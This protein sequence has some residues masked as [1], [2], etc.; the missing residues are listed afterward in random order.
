MSDLDLPA[1]PPDV[2]STGA[3]RGWTPWR[4]SRSADAPARRDAAATDPALTA[5][6]R[7]HRLT[8]FFTGRWAGRRGEGGLAEGAVAD[9]VEDS[10]RNGH[11]PEW[12]IVEAEPTSQV[13]RDLVH[14]PGVAAWALGDRL[15]GHGGGTGHLTPS[16]A[17]RCRRL[18]R[19]ARPRVLRPCRRRQR[20]GRR[21]LGSRRRGPCARG[22]QR[23]CWR[24]R[25]RPRR[26]RG[27]R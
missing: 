23:G 25:P 26:R 14:E 21:G 11:R 13:G 7:S 12:V 4:G 24:S 17:D 22:P 1:V 3:V 2:G 6:R 19:D 5:I 10:Q 16:P 20:R 27:H 18:D 15:V 8:R 9:G